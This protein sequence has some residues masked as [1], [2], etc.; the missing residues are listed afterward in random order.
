MFKKYVLCIND[1]VDGLSYYKIYTAIYCKFK[2]EK[3]YYGLYDDYG[4]YNLFLADRFITVTESL[5]ANIIE[6]KTS[7][8]K[9]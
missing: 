2:K 5:V 7:N 6:H 1:L 4:M 9:M 8:G 3:L